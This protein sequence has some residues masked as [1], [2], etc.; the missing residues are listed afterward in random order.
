MFILEEGHGSVTGLSV[1][2]PVCRHAHAE[3]DPK[4]VNKRHFG[5]LLPREKVMQHISSNIRCI[6][7]FF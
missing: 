4:P 5:G 7:G 3:M 1:L 2:T 6:V